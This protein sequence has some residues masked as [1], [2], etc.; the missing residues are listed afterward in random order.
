ML[1][2]LVKKKVK[3]SNLVL[4]VVLFLES[5]ALYLISRYVK[6]TWKSLSS[7]LKTHLHTRLVCK[8]EESPFKVL[9]S[10]MKIFRAIC[11]FVFFFFGIRATKFP[12]FVCGGLI[13]LQQV[14]I[15]K[16]VLESLFFQSAALLTQFLILYNFFRIYITDV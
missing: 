16:V 2:L 11:L 10:F 8:S 14:L 3:Q 13:S 12:D 6:H 1:T 5:K 7:D 4:V 15:K 9:L